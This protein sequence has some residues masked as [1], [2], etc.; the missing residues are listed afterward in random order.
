MIA[1]QKTAKEIGHFETAIN[2]SKV[3]DST[4]VIQKVG[5]SMPLPDG[6]IDKKAAEVA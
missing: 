5:A 6:D 3:K 1:I 2:L 4:D